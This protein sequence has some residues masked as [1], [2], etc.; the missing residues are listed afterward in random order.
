[1]KRL[2]IY[3]ILLFQTILKDIYIALISLN[4]FELQVSLI[5]YI[6][7]MVKLHQYCHNLSPRS[8]LQHIFW[9]NKEMCINHLYF[10]LFLAIDTDLDNRYVQFYDHIC[11]L[12]Y[13]YI[14]CFIL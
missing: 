6:Y 1:V 7:E 8:N 3:L 14:S 10:N 2:A 9:F 13:S 5:T 11:V 12:S 4:N